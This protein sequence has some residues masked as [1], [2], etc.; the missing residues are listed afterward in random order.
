MLHTIH[1]H[2]LCCEAMFVHFPYF[3]GQTADNFPSLGLKEMVNTLKR[4]IEI[5]LF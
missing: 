3:A 2:H 5:W 4:L 1:I